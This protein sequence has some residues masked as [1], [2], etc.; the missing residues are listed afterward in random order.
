[1]SAA[2]LFGLGVLTLAVGDGCGAGG[3]AK[4]DAKA[5]EIVRVASQTE[6]KA[7]KADYSHWQFKGCRI[8]RW[9]G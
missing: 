7:S 6:L 4:Q 9:M 2:R 3:M 8:R 5:Q 1:M